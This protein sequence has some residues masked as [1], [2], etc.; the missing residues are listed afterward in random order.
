MRIFSKDSCGIGVASVVEETCRLWWR[1]YA[2]APL[3]VEHMPWMN[4]SIVFLM[5]EFVCLI[6]CVWVD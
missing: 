6:L 4:A 1:R 2:G 5:S 3:M